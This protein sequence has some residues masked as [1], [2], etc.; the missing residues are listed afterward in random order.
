MYDH[1][2]AQQLTDVAE[3]LVLPDE[4]QALDAHLASCQFCREA[5]NNRQAAVCQW[6]EGLPAYL[7][8]VSPPST[9][10]WRSIRD[11][12]PRERKVDRSTKAWRPVRSATA[13]VATLAVL[14][15]L[16]IGLYFLFRQMAFPTAPEDGPFPTREGQTVS[17]PIFEM[18]SRLNLNSDPFNQPIDV[19]VRAALPAF[20]DSFPLF[21][22]ELALDEPTPDD[23]RQWAEHL[24]LGSVRVYQAERGSLTMSDGGLVGVS[25]NWDVIS[26]S[27]DVKLVR[28]SFP[29]SQ[30]FFL[31]LMDA[32]F[33]SAVNE[34]AARAAAED[35]LERLA[36]HLVTVQ[37]VEE[38]PHI[39]L[40]ITPDPDANVLGT[41]FWIFQVEPVIDGVHIQAGG[42]TDNVV[43][44]G[45][46]GDIVAAM[47]SR[48]NLIPTGVWASPRPP[49]AVVRDFL[50]DEGNLLRGTELSS[51]ATTPDER[52]ETFN[53]PVTYAP[54]DQ[55]EAVGWLE[56][57]RGLD[58]EPD[59]MMLRAYTPPQTFVLE[60]SE[61]PAE[62][63]DRVFQVR[64]TLGRSE[65]PGVW[66]LQV[67]RFETTETLAGIREGWAEQRD[68][69]FWFQTNDGQSFFL[70]DPPHGLYDRAP[71]GVLG[72]PAAG[73]ATRLDWYTIVILH[74]QD[75]AANQVFRGETQLETGPA[76]VTQV[77]APPPM[78]STS[79]PALSGEAA[80]TDAAEPSGVVVAAQPAPEPG[81]LPPWWDYQPGDVVTV[82][83][84][85]F[86]HGYELPDGKAEIFASLTVQGPT[87]G[88]EIPYVPVAG[89]DLAK[90]L[91]L[92]QLHVRLRAQ[93]LSDGDTEA[94][95]GEDA[96]PSSPH[97]QVLWV[98]GVEQLWPEEKK[99]IYSGPVRIESVTGEPVALLEDELSGET[100]A[101]L[102]DVVATALGPDHDERT[103]VA[104]IGV[105]E[106]GGAVAGFPAL[107]VIELRVGEGQDAPLKERLDNPLSKLTPHGVQ[108]PSE[109]IIEEVKL[110]YRELLTMSPDGQDESEFEVLYLLIGRSP[111]GQYQVTFRLEPFESETLP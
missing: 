84:L 20:P 24:G 70:P 60:G 5:L 103:P 16:A 46:E 65:G 75:R 77:P 73:D 17:E 57:L 106:A 64:G 12:V 37:G 99:A 23:V 67:D 62:V 3:G 31:G 86:V 104:L 58:G 109:V 6:R 21:R 93:V 72:L 69:G 49:E 59:L 11:R 94:R 28:T 78:T 90:L 51:P 9:L 39:S 50:N 33:G 101:L 79:L 8:R 45:P 107:R 54:G 42:G 108:G 10:H 38:A 43:L 40:S 36:P 91:P 34:T 96:Y 105:Q 55:I 97:G 14:T 87:E 92:D 66:R 76:G 53:R 32:A 102:A 26:L 19:T 100:F 22:I 82:V 7:G 2:S 41:G 98:E 56:V 1:L 111:D 48:L 74:E 88:D 68:E 80:P 71:V 95:M 30:P 52:P 44:V 25:P 81:T 63:R 61:L 18:S 85:L 4:R 110:V 89:E 13:S 83:G 27:S 47:L 35:F 15:A 29:L